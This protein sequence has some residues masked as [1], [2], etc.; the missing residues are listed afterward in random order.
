MSGRQVKRLRERVAVANAARPTWVKLCHVHTIFRDRID[1]EF[2]WVTERSPCLVHTR[3]T[4][5]RAALRQ[6]LA[7]AEHVKPGRRFR[8]EAPTNWEPYHPTP[9]PKETT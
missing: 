9:T 3:A 2:A 4:T 6:V 1:V 5:E 7:I 8:A